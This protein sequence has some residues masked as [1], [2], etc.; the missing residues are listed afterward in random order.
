M[1]TDPRRDWRDS[2]VGLGLV[3]GAGIGATIGVLV[4]GGA[5]IAL[6]GA[7]GAGVGVVLGAVARSMYAA[8]RR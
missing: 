1:T 4:T 7:M 3:L 5:G 2:L 8:D 6:G